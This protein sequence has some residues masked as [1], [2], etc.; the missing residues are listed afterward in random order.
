MFFSAATEPGSSESSNE[1]WVAATPDMVIVLDGVTVNEEFR[2]SCIH[3]TPWYVKQLGTRLLT[4]A[5]H[6]KVSLKDALR[7]AISATARLHEDTC[8]L[9]QIGA[10]SAAA[11]VLR[12]NQHEIEYIVLADITIVLKGSQGLEII[13]DDRVSGSVEDLTGKSNSFAEIMERR[14]RYRNRE[15]GYWVA[16]ADPNV[17]DHVVAG[18]MPKEDFD[19]AAVMSDGVSRLV[20]TFDHLSWTGLMDLAHQDGPSAVIQ[21]IRKLELSDTKRERWPRFKV[22]D[23]A[24]LA[25]VSAD[26]APK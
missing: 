1:D 21:T 9:H 25:L 20:H 4:E 15:N 8:Q 24:T 5:A 23:D 12:V 11:A 6:Y 2:S 13:S 10:P 17:V 19:S 16:A 3:G 14:S 22:S 26:P 7:S 18:S